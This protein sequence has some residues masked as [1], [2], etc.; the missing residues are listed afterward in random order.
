[1]YLKII[2]LLALGV[3]LAGFGIAAPLLAVPA[4][5]LDQFK[6]RAAKFN[7]IISLPQLETATNE[8]SASVQ[9]TIT[10]GNG[11]LDRVGALKAK[12]VN[13]QN[14]VRALDDLGHQIACTAN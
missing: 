6:K 13:F 14:T 8:I 7:A 11:A 3:L 12:E 10:A 1:M 9:R 2:C 5:A 4:D